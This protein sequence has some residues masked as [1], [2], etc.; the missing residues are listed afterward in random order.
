MVF[1]P[2]IMTMTIAAILAYLF[3]PMWVLVMFGVV[4][5]ALQARPVHSRED[6]GNRLYYHKVR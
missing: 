5:C 4:L 3:I 1:L 2:N 6:S